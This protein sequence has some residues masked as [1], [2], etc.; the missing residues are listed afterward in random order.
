[1]LIADVTFTPEALTVV[2]ALLASLTTACSVVFYQL[3]AA[4]N[5]RAG[6]AAILRKELEDTRKE[7]LSELKL[8]RETYQQVSAQQVQTFIAT[9]QKMEDGFE[10]RHEKLLAEIRSYLHRREV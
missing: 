8:Q 7:Y 10:A 2:G 5:E 1:M 3:I 9:Q 4:K 6:D